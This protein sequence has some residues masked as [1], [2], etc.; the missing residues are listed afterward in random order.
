[1]WK[2]YRRS[3]ENWIVDILQP[4]IDNLAKPDYINRIEVAELNL[5]YEPL[6]FRNVQRIT[7]R[8]ANDLQ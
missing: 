3:V 8:R 1:M 7:S 2:I 5:D 6:A 4:A